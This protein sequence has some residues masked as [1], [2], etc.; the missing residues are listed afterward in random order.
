MSGPIFF[1]SKRNYLKRDPSSGSTN[2][3][4]PVTP[5]YTL[6]GLFVT[7]FT[8]THN[9]GFVPLVRVAYEPFADGIIW[10]P[11]GSRLGGFAVNPTNTAAK[12]PGLIV[13]PTSTTLQLQLFF[14]ANTLIGTFPTY[15]TIYKDFAL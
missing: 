14:N 8:V 2:M 7:N 13:W 5:A 12:G 15:F 3:A 11:M 10:P 1:T 9:L 6:E 4:A